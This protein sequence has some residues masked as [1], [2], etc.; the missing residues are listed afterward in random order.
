MF[1]CVNFFFDVLQV[2][3][4]TLQQKYTFL[5]RPLLIL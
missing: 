4:S 1:S 3:I 2:F 5:E